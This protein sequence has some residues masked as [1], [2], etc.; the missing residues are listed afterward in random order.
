LLYGSGTASAVPLSANLTSNASGVELALNYNDGKLFYK[1][2]GGVVR[3]LASKATGSIGGST[4]QIQ[5]NSSGVLA[6]SSSL[7]FSGTTLAVTTSSGGDAITATDGTVSARIAGFASS[8]LNIGTTSAHSAYISTNGVQRFGVNS[9]G[10]VSINAPNSSTALTVTG[11]SGAN[12][13]SFQAAAASDAGIIFGITSSQQWNLRTAY[14][15]GSFRLYDQTRVA[16]P[17]I[18][19]TAGNVTIGF[20]S[21]GAA[22]TVTGLNAAR[23]LSNACGSAV[24][25]FD[26][27]FGVG[28]A[29]GYWNLFTNGADPLAIGTGGA[30]QFALYTNQVPRIYITSGGNVGVGTTS[31]ATRLQS[32]IDATDVNVGQILASGTTDTNKR[33][34]LG[35]HTTSNYGFIQALIAGTNTYDLV[36]QPNGSNLGLGVTPS[37]WAS[38]AKALQIKSYSCLFESSAGK[39]ILAFN[40]RESAANV[41]SYLQTEYASCYQQVSGGHYWFNAASGTLGN[42]ITFTQAMTLDT[43]GNLGIGVTPSAWGGSYKVIQFGGNSVIAGNDVV[44]ASNT[45]NNGTNW[46]YSTNNYATRYEPNFGA[47]GVHAW[48]VAPSGTAGNAITFTEAMRITSTGNVTIAAP[49]SGTALST[50]VASSATF[51]G[52][53]FATNAINSDL[54]VRIKTSVSDLYNSAGSITFSTGGSGGTEALRITSGGNVGIGTTSPSQKLT[55]SV[56]DNNQALSL[57]ATTGRIRFRPYV[58]ATS[59]AIIESLNPAELSYLPLSFVGSQVRLTAD[60]ASGV[61]IIGTA[62]STAALRI[63]TSAAVGSQ[64]AT[65]P[66]INPTNKPGSG[67]GSLSKWIPINLDGTTYY[68]PAW[69]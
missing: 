47:G 54:L 55:V 46:V 18:V 23:T 56:G 2:S 3:V 65:W 9:S 60:T 52:A 45:Y 39:T 25:S 15:D 68:I 42:A 38:G 7:T 11:Q 33:L 41:Y 16:Y 17:L 63:D 22:L 51:Q 48:F 26:A 6:G 31:P 29:G 69:S 57:Q 24:S 20:P 10:N 66:T 59:G 49:N 61:V 1:D 67:T 21:S 32:A 30:S 53:I 27:G 28:L 4:T 12:I 34:S 62:A 36:L 37:A 44:L 58:D 50:S 35:F 5:Y 19:S 13:A 64:T 8:T 40:A 43:S 14:S